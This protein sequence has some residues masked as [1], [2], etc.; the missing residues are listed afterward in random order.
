[1][2]TLS[3]WEFN[4]SKTGAVARTTRHR[5]VSSRLVQTDRLDSATT[6][7]MARRARRTR[8]NSG[9]T[10]SSAS[11]W[12]RAPTARISRRPRRPCSSRR[13]GRSRATCRT[14]AMRAGRFATL[15]PWAQDESTAA[16]TAT[17]QNPTATRS[18][19][20]ARV[21]VG[22]HWCRSTDSDTS[23]TS[24]ST[25]C[26]AY[27]VYDTY[28]WMAT[29]G[30]PGFRYTAAMARYAGVLALRF[31]N[32]DLLPYD[33]SAYGREIARYARGLAELPGA[34][35]LARELGG[36]AERAESWSAAASA[37]EDAQSGSGPRAGPWRRGRPLRRQR[38][39]PLLERCCATRRSAATRLVQAP[40]LR[41]A[42]V[43]PRGDA[44]RH[45]RGAGRRRRRRRAH[46]GR[47]ARPADRRGHR[48]RAASRR[49]RRGDRARRS[50]RPAA[51]SDTTA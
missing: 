3:Q 8:T 38:L 29:Q 15:P 21:A 40:G 23:T 5:L 41:S 14:P 49:D 30:D 34:G 16:T 26:T 36:L 25:A 47:A 2:N 37:A 24:P 10:R 18:A 39:A 22:A 9:R 48:R 7:P 6:A 50:Y 28:R 27:P 31:A 4:R 19:S 43:L 12:T 20:S 45:P 17:P 46:R 13:S 44:A 35:A 11:T 33:A 42:A 51:T 1:M 32:A